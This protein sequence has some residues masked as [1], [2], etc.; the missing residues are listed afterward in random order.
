MKIYQH[1]SKETQVQKS[2]FILN[3]PSEQQLNEQSKHLK[4][5][6][7]VK[8]L[9]NKRKFMGQLFKEVYY[10]DTLDVEVD[11]ADTVEDVKKKTGDAGGWDLC[12]ESLILGSNILNCEIKMKDTGVEEGSVLVCGVMEVVVSIEWKSPDLGFPLVKMMGLF[13]RPWDTVGGLVNMLRVREKFGEE[14][15]VNLKHGDEEL[16]EK[17]TLSESSIGPDTV[18]NMEFV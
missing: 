9:T 16:E 5:K 1:I 18:L 13:V 11:E 2:M 4:M 6:V 14:V 3:T 12:D 7:K 8:V 10:W 17:K 15:R